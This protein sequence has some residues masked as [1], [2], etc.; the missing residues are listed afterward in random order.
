M[1]HKELRINRAQQYNFIYKNGRR[2]IGKFMI[3]FVS[4]NPLQEIR[5]GAVTSKRIGN[6]VVR[7]RAKRQIREVIRKNWTGLPKGYD[8][9]VVARHSIKGVAFEQIESEFLRL[10]RKAVNK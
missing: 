2:I 7:N 5:A 4:R 10:I 3:L 1:L 6:A 9:V 8:L